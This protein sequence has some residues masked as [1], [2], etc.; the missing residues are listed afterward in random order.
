M[1][2]EHI[3]NVHRAYKSTENMSEMAGVMARLEIHKLI[4][5][6]EFPVRGR[7]A[8]SYRSRSIEHGFPHTFTTRDH[9]Q[10]TLHKLQVY[11]FRRAR[12]VPVPR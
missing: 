4:F 3:K 5:S 6:D 7:Y 12:R 2:Y 8:S 10:R 11:R 1:V 9:Q